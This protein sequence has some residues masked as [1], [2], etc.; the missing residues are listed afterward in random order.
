[1]MLLHV[2]YTELAS[3]TA[4]FAKGAATLG[5]AEEHTALSR[6]LAQLS[7]AFEKVEGLHQ[8]VA[9]SD[10]YNVSEVIGDYVRVIGEIKVG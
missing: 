6:A 4:S 5:N 2:F 9:N 8:E 7:E 10:F 1:M 3:N